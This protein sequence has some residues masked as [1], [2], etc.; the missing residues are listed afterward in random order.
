VR[1]DAAIIGAGAD[2]LAA[3]ILLARA[4]LEV[5]VIERAADPGGRCVTIPFAPGYRAPPFIDDVPAIPAALAQSLGL[6]QQGVVLEEVP[7]DPR[8]LFR[9][10]AILARARREAQSLVPQ[11]MWG[12]LQAHMAQQA[13]EA[14]VWP[15]IDWAD[16]AIADTGIAADATL[17]GR[18]L[19]PE[20]AGS[21]LA[22]LTAHRSRVVGGSL[23]TLGR[24]L[25]AA[26][27]AAGVEIK[28]QAEASEIRLHRRKAQAL[29]LADGSEIE[30]GI[31]LSTLD[32]KRTFLSLFPWTGLPAPLL[33]A[34]RDWRVQGARARLLVA[35]RAPTSLETP[36][37]QPGDGDAL[38]AFRRGA[39]P[40]RPPLLADPVSRRD[41]SLAPPGGSVITVTLGAIPHTLFD[42]PWDGAKRAMLAARA[43]ARLEG[44]ARG[45][46]ASLAGL[47]IIVP[48]D[49]EEMLGASGG[50]L[51]GGQIAPDQ[52]LG[53]RP[54][55]R[56]AIGGLYLAGASAQA[57][58]HGACVGGAA[59]AAA[60]LADRGGDAA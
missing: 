57:A 23:D 7:A 18:A 3:A 10:D 33:A 58:P 50:D 5:I 34:A 17:A 52:M 59:A 46:V 22:L 54:G 12:K 31:I 21:A 9:R 29:V 16:K 8:I 45:T 13:G 32:F 60:I 43:L 1:Y 30:T 11:S 42:G 53:F 56:S 35:L 38:A 6:A 55:P 49:I 37:F 28:C 24:A 19:D 44:I 26:A 27:R 40:D 20:L 51:D 14:P 36:L 48:P 15:G 47:R 2:G 4:N 39:V 25:A 41:P